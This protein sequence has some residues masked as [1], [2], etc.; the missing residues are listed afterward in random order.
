MANSTNPG[1]VVKSQFMNKAV[2][3]CTVIS[4][5]LQCVCVCTVEGALRD[6]GT[7][8][9]GNLHAQTSSPGLL[10]HGGLINKQH[11]KSPRLDTA[12]AHTARS[13]PENSGEAAR[14]RPKMLMAEATWTE[15]V[16]R[17]MRKLPRTSITQ[18]RAQHQ[19]IFVFLLNCGQ[20]LLET[21]TSMR[22]KRDRSGPRCNMIV[23]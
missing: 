19:T 18:A 16:Q 2:V 17:S 1:T 6:L 14:A 11:N 20:L 10:G 13:S 22:R 12:H 15:V 4:S 9:P 23:T 5:I 21:C 3:L 8:R 7:R